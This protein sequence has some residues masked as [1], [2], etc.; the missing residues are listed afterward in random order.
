MARVP[1]W[2]MPAFGWETRPPQSVARSRPAAVALRFYVVQPS[3][4]LF[5]KP[6]NGLRIAALQ[7]KGFMG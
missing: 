4:V 6:Q 5:P 3:T 2:L 7:Y 1:S